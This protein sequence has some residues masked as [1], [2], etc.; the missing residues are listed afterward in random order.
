MSTQTYVAQR[1]FTLGKSGLQIV[2]GESLQF[3]GTDVIYQG[4]AITFP[5]F[6]GTVNVGWVAL[7]GTTVEELPAVAG[8][9]IRPADGGNPMQ[10]K[11]RQPIDTQAVEAEEREVA[12]VGAHSTHTAQRNATNYRRD[13]RHPSVVVEE[14][15]GVPVRTLKT[16]AGEGAKH[17]R[18]TLTS[19]SAHQAIT[20][21]SAVSIEPGQGMSR[22]EMLERMSPSDRA[23]YE[24]KIASRRAQYVD[25]EPVEVRRVQPTQ[26]STSE[27]I[28]A[29]V[30]TGG[31]TEVADLGGGDQR[32]ARQEVIEAEGIRFGTTNGPQKGVQLVQPPAPVPARSNGGDGVARQIAKSV[33]P[34]FPD[35]YDFS[36]STRKKIARLQADYD[37]R[38]DVIRAV[39]AADTD[40]EVRQ[41]LIEEFPEVFS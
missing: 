17:R 22:E 27:G 36:A 21:A 38:P 5:Q 18:T 30:M 34:D 2:K 19:T 33:C 32:P 35:N 20:E 24:A 1:T 9:Q 12:S 31:G 28:T 16:A 25:D 23:Q 6:R 4:Q 39:A 29:A 13:P 3:N 14:Q 40:P 10:P 26:A 8:M 41:R 11:P 37:D 15:D 7:S